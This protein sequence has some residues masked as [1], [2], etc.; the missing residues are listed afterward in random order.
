MGDT[1][2]SEDVQFVVQLPESGKISLLKDGEVGTTAEGIELSYNTRASG[3]YRV[4]VKK[5]K[6]PWIFSNHIRFTQ[7]ENQ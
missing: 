2:K 6:K 4:E 7:S 3:A 1:V 5:K